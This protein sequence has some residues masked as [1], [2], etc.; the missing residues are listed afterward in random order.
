MIRGILSNSYFVSRI[1]FADDI[2]DGSGRVASVLTVLFSFLSQL[3]GATAMSTLVMVANG[4]NALI[5]LLALLWG[6]AAVRSIVKSITGQL[7]FSNSVTRV[8]GPASRVIPYWDIASEL[9]RRIWHPFWE[10]VLL[11][12]GEVYAKRLSDMQ[13]KA[14]DVGKQRVLEHWKNAAD[15]EKNRVRERL[16]NDYEGVD[17]Y[18]KAV[19]FMR[20]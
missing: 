1:S 15:E 10:A 2:L 17:V 7:Q 14:R 20:L 5:M 3:G 9:K 6:V 4:V 11:E 8:T 16:M 13:S 12:E 18:Y 19:G